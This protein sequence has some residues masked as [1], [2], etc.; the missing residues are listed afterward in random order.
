VK[1]EALRSALSA[2]ARAGELTVVDS[3][4]LPE[5]KTRALQ[6][7]LLA[8][9]TQGRVLLV[10]AEPNR[11]IWRCGRNIPALRIRPAVDV[12]AHDVLLA[13]RVIIT[14]DAVP[15]LEARLS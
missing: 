6:E 2:R 13:H 1:T 8:L 4:D 12:N 3:L 14:K 10:L 11:L 15:R 5:P 7:I 9:G